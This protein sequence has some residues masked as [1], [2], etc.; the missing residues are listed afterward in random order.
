MKK[1]NVFT[2]GLL[3]VAAALAHSATMKAI[4]VHEFGGPEVLKYE[5]APRPQPEENEILV[6][7]ISAGVNPVDTYVRSGKFG[8]AG[9]PPLI[10]GRD[11][12]GIVEELGLGATKFKK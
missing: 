1:K 11:I 12:A 7:V 6:R 5:D 3:I 9:T 2:V 4:V 8:A 10:P